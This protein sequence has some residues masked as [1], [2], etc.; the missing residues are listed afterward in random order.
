MSFAHILAFKALRWGCRSGYFVLGSRATVS[1]DYL[2]F[3]RISSGEEEAEMRD[4]ER[5]L[6]EISSAAN[7]LALCAQLVCLTALCTG[8]WIHCMCARVVPTPN[9]CG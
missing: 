5:R 9:E 8:S 2:N 7:T 6:I 3:C 1:D 4:W